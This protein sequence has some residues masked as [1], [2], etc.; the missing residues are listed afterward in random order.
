MDKIKDVERFFSEELDSFYIKEEIK[1]FV[2]LLLSHLRGYERKD[3]IINEDDLLSK[4]EI[5]YLKNALLR[6]KKSEPIQYIIGYTEFYEFKIFTDKRALIPRPETEEMVSLILS[7]NQDVGSI[8]DIGTGSGCIPISLKKNLPNA[9]VVAWD[10]SEDALALANKN[11]DYNKVDIKFEKVDVLSAEISNK[12][13]DIIVS[14]PPY[15]TPI[16]K[17]LMQKNVLE[18]EPH[19]ALFVEM[20]N[21]LIFYNKIAALGSKILNDKGNLY[22]EINENYGNETLQLLA[23]IG[24]TSLKVVKDLSGRDR[25]IRAT[26]VY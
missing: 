26:W 11:A 15:V 14:N 5:F 2:L 4:E 16:D 3:I 23:D 22:F 6:L 10:I 20:D 8:L 13:Y 19:L 18:Y 21:P 17:E 25:M 9:K 1:S 24:Y 7:E 12:K